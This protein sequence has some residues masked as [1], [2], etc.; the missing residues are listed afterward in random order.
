[1][2]SWLLEGGLAMLAALLGTFFLISSVS[3]GDAAPIGFELVAGPLAFAGLVLFRR[4]RPVALTLVLIPLGVFFGLPMGATPIALFSVAL[5]RR[6]RVA[7]LLAMLHAVLVAGVYLIALGPTA[8]YV[9]SV[10]FLVLLHVSLV[11]V[12]MVIR[13][14]RLLVR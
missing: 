11:A 14:H 4:N 8:N 3:E 1:V 2:R 6:A 13:S 12:A 9:Q 7:V 5:H 10:I